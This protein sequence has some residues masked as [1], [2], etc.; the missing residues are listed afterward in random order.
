MPHAE[1]R[2]VVAAAL[3]VV[4]GAYACVFLFQDEPDLLIAARSGSPL[5]LGVGQ[6][7]YML[8]SDASAIVEH[9][10]EVV[11]LKEGSM[12][13]IKRSGYKIFQHSEIVADAL[14]ATGSFSSARPAGSMLQ[15]DTE[16]NPIVKL[17]MSLAQIEKGGYEHFM[18]K[19]IMDQPN[20][21]RNAM[22][23]R[24]HYEDSCDGTSTDNWKMQA[25]DGSWVIAPFKPPPRDQVNAGKKC[26]FT[27]EGESGVVEFTSA[28]EGVVKSKGKEYFTK[29]QEAPSPRGALRIKLGGLEKIPEGALGGETFLDKISNSQR[30]IICACGTSWHSGLIAKYVLEELAEVTCEV[31]YASEFRYRKPLISRGDCIFAISQSG[32]T[33]DTL[34]AI[35]MAKENGALTIGIVNG[36]GSSIARGTDAGVY[37]HAGPEIGVASTKAFSCQT[38][39]VIM[40]ALRLAHRKGL[41]DDEELERNLS[42][43]E[44]LPSTLEQWLPQLNEQ[45]RDIARYFRLASNALFCGCGVHFPVAL[46][47]ALKLKEISYIHAE[48][49][50]GAEIKHAAL[51]LV[52]RF[53]PVFL[54]AFSSSPSYQE[55]R[56]SVTDLRERRAAVIV[57]TEEGNE[58]FDGLASFVIRCP[59]TEV[60]LEPL[61]SVIP[62]QLL[63]YHI[64]QMRGCE[65]DQPK[66]LAKSVTVE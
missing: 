27:Y 39:M 3:H 53:L 1:W 61:L 56:E 35:K 8:G 36:V 44:A 10:Q 15:D 43:M 51:T 17:E 20:S 64:A 54:V 33:A 45:T 19:E 66:N 32:E 41:M 18:L 14:R 21:L 16:L 37:L 40:I 7:E 22:R 42:A 2:Q 38:A 28:N 63:S 11:Y 9:T 47:G 59:R 12:I 31:E 5:I 24:I 58:D 6:D 23:G 46:E 4:K 34:E 52:E 50:P 25:S 30:I 57:L 55:V 29:L 13:E 60:P 65:I 49:F 48:G 26:E 62:M